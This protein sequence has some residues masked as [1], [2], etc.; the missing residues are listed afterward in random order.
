MI[1]LL[2]IGFLIFVYKQLNTTKKQ[3][4][5]IEEKQTEITD[6]INYAKK[7]QDALI[8][9]WRYFTFYL[10]LPRHY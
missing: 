10:L 6:S 2:V 7:I 3:K 9:V 1:V 5:V 8:I 4:S